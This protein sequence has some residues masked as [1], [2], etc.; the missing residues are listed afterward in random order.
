MKVYTIVKWVTTTTEHRVRAD[1]YDEAIDLFESG[2]AE[3]VPDSFDQE[4]DYEVES[5]EEE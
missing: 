3:E 4:V 5:I 2:E 1:S